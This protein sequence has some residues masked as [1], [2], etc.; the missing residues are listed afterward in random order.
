[1]GTENKAT[2][3]QGKRGFWGTVGAGCRYIGRT[4]SQ[5]PLKGDNRD[6]FQICVDGV[7]GKGPGRKVARGTAY[8]GVAITAASIVSGSVT[9]TIIGGVT[10]ASGITGEVVQVLRGRSRRTEAAVDA[11]KVTDEQAVESLGIA[12]AAKAEDNAAAVLESV[13][14]GPIFKLSK[15]KWNQIWGRVRARTPMNKPDTLM[16]AAIV[17]LAERDGLVTVA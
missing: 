15:D 6:L 5:D 16:Y 11:P 1:M 4:L 10:A 17:A 12:T 7:M 13:A 3:T 8:T 14:T 9:G 2:E